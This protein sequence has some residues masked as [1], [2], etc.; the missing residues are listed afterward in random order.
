[1]KD[2]SWAEPVTEGEAQS[3]PDENLREY[4]R[5]YLDGE[6]VK[7]TTMKLRYELYEAMKD[8]ANDRS[9]PEEAFNMSEM[10]RYALNEMWGHLLDDKAGGDE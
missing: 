7:Q 6:T 5:E 10:T 2:E 9:G 8:E 3:V 1:M 4:G